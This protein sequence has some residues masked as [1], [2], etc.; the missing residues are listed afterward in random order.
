MTDVYGLPRERL[1]ATVHHSDDEAYELWLKETDIEPHRVMRFGAENF[2][3]MGAIGP[4]GTSSEIHF[5]LGDLRTQKSTFSHEKNGVNGNSHRYVELINFVFMDSEKLPDGSLK[6]LGERHIDT[7][8]GFERLCAVVQGVRSNYETDLFRPLTA[9]IAQLTSVV[10]DEGPQGTAHRVISDHIRAVAFAVADGVRPA[11]EGR[12][13]VIRRILRRALRYAHSLGAEKPMLY[14]LIPTLSQIMGDAFPELREQ[15]AVVMDIVAGEEERFLTTLS[16]GLGRLDDLLSQLKKQAA[17]VVPGSELFA[18]YDTYGFPL[19]LSAQ[20][21]KEK[22]FAID[23]VGYQESMEQQKTRARGAQKFQALSVA[24]DA[25]ARK[26]FVADE[27]TNAFVGYHDLE[28]PRARTLWVEVGDGGHHYVCCLEVTPFYPT[29]GGQ[30]GD[31]G[32]LENPHLTLEVVASEYRHKQ[33]VHHCRLQKGSPSADL[34]EFE[35]FDARVDEHVRHGSAIHH[36]A[37]HL[38][39]AALREH[40]GDGVGQQGSYLD[41]EGLRFDFSFHRALTPRELNT[42]EGLVNDKIRRAQPVRARELLLRQA[43]ELGALYLPGE[44]YGE[45]VRVLS[46]GRDDA[47]L[48]LELCCGTHVK[49]TGELG[50]FVVIAESAVAAGIRRITALAGPAAYRWSM[51]QRQELSDVYKSLKIPMQSSS[52]L[53]LNELGEMAES[54]AFSSVDKIEKLMMQMQHLKSEVA[55]LTAEKV[56]GRLDEMLRDAEECNAGYRVVMQDLSSEWAAEQL[57]F[58]LDELST[59][60]TVASEA[61]VAVFWHMSSG[62]QPEGS[63]KGTGKGKKQHRSEGSAQLLIL[64][65]VSTTLQNRGWHAGKLAGYLCGIWGGRGGGRADRARGGIKNLQRGAAVHVPQAIEEAVKK[66]E[67]PYLTA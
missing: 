34:R 16:S 3:E 6:P 25:G 32:V 29:S 10:Y 31:V 37:T 1:F 62:R 24:A 33:I 30:L 9:C 18:L 61:Y 28:V 58:F 11:A 7:G 54:K 47:P 44:S 52:G 12:G 36:S 19:D 23:K 42:I 17:S 41:A 67:P 39:H 8:A 15:Q 4:C 13:Y 56:R 2:W 26:V 40:L 5:D 53:K 66:G 49:C 59:K 64:T 46:M 65:A 57:N 63:D 14:Q 48:S 20:I 45:S 55:E 50:L 51:V 35:Y 27:K 21:A 38:L 22:G 43:Q 60:I